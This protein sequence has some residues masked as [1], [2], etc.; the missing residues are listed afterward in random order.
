MIFKMALRNIL[1]QQR[2]SFFTVL[3]MIFGMVIVAFSISLT[4]GTY[5]T[6]ISTFTESQT[7]HIQLHAKGYLDSPSLYKTIK[8]PDFVE[9]KLKKSKDI[10]SFSSRVYSG[11]LAFY[12][13]KSTGIAIQGIDPEAEDRITNLSSKW[14]DSKKFVSKNEKAVII[15]T[16]LA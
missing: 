4:D 12:K 5:N 9:S 7:G 8:N 16:S 11:G 10:V 6:I 13:K 15:S 2:R 14:L 3:G 1:R